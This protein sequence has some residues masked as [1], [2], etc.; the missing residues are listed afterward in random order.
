MTSFDN[1]FEVEDLWRDKFDKKEVTWN[2]NMRV[3][4]IK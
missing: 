2:V 3:G 1:M 4:I